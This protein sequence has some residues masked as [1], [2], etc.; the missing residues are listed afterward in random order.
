VLGNLLR[1]ADNTQEM[2]DSIEKIVQGSTDGNKKASAGFN[3]MIKRETEVSDNESKRRANEEEKR[4]KEDTLRE[5]EDHKVETYG[6]RRNEPPR[7]MESKVL[8]HPECELDLP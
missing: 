7:F 1:I 4:Y 5:D 8:K 2:L 6:D 3:R